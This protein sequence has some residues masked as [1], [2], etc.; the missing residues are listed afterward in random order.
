MTM[1]FHLILHAFVQQT[2]V[3]TCTRHD[4]HNPYPTES[5]GEGLYQQIITVPFRGMERKDSYYEGI[6][7]GE[8]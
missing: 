3:S 4:I 1:A 5:T 7:W 6:V 2:C 8:G